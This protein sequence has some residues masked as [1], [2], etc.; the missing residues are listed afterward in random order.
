VLG[1][2]LVSVCLIWSAVTSSRLRDF[3]CN[4]I[5]SKFHSSTISRWARHR[6]HLA[7]WMAYILPHQVLRRHLHQP[8][9]QI[10]SIMSPKPPP[11]GSSSRTAL[12]YSSSITW[13]SPKYVTPRSIA[14]AKPSVGDTNNTRI[15]PPSSWNRWSRRW[16]PVTLRR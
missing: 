2:S 14:K 10:W 9:K 15:S 11:K 13:T 3:T 4:P 1:F 6:W 5:W 12:W 7:L 8:T 16:T